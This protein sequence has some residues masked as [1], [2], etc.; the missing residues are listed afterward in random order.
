MCAGLL[1]QKDTGSR[2]NPS[3]LPADLGKLVE[4]CN[5]RPD[6]EASHSEF[7]VDQADGNRIHH[8]LSLKLEEDLLGASSAREVQEYSTA[9]VSLLSNVSGVAAFRESDRYIRD[10]YKALQQKREKDAYKVASSDTDLEV[11]QRTGMLVAYKVSPHSEEGTYY[12]FGTPATR[13]FLNGTRGAPSPNDGTRWGLGDG[14]RL[15][16]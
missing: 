5:G 7:C 4:L 11:L 12:I 6:N 8:F 14:D 15:Q 10:R 9:R 1:E 2:R 16:C 13:Q 3:S